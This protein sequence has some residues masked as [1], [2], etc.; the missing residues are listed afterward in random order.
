MEIT[1]NIP[2]GF[3]ELVA[4][5]KD[6]ARAVLEA[7]A[8]EGYR[9]HKLSESDVKRLLGYGTRMQ[10]HALLKEHDVYLHH[11]AEDLAEDIRTSREFVQKRRAEIESQKSIPR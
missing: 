8:V 6:P 9:L 7:L 10:V 5:G 4:P 1:L 11:S 3:A 2:D